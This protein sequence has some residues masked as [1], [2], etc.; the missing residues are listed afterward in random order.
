MRRAW[1]LARLAAFDLAVVTVFA[2][3]TIWIFDDFYP[4]TPIPSTTIGHIVLALSCTNS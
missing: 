4:I 1:T 3:S 2:A